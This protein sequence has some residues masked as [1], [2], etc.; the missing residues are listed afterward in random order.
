[1]DN[2]PDWAVSI[3][4]IAVG[5]GPWLAVLSA[6]SIARLLYRALSPRPEVMRQRESEP[7]RNEPG[8]RS[9][10]AGVTE[11]GELLTE[12][13]SGDQHRPAKDLHPDAAITVI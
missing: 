12:N 10:L 11:F 9:S 1:M 2:L 8:P 7:T 3:S 13:P 5:L 4:A 6:R